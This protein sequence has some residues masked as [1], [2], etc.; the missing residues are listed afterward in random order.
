MALLGTACA[1]A[2]PDFAYLGRHCEVT[3]PWDWPSELASAITF[4]ADPLVVSVAGALR[5]FVAERIEIHMMRERF[6]G[7]TGTTETEIRR[8]HS[9]CLGLLRDLGERVLAM[10]REGRTSAGDL[11]AARA[12]PRED[13]AILSGAGGP[14]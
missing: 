11:L 3:V 4:A 12:Q 5:V 6:L 1:A 13:Q 9:M 10:A 14:N 7:E 2:R 8:A